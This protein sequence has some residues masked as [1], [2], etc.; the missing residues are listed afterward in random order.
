MSYEIDQIDKAVLELIA[1]H[2][3]GSLG[4]YAVYPGLRNEEITQMTCA[5]ILRYMKNRTDSGV[6]SS[7]CGKYQ[8]IRVS[9]SDTINTAGIDPRTTLYSEEVQD[10]LILTRLKRYRKHNDW[11]S[12]E[13]PTDKYM[14]KLAQEFASMPVPYAMKGASRQL[15]K[16]QSYYAGDGLNSAHHDPDTLYTQLE[17]IKAGGTGEITSVDVTPAGPNQG[18]SVIGTSPRTQ[19]ERAVSGT[20]ST[21]SPDRG[22]PG[23]QPLPNSAL[24]SAG[25]VY[26]Y[27]PIDP[28]DDRYDFRTGTHVRD[29][30]VYGTD[31]VA[32]N[33]VVATN[34]GESNSVI[35]SGV[36][37]PDVDGEDPRGKDQIPQDPT[38]AETNDTAAATS[39]ADDL[40]A[41]LDAFGGLGEPVSDQTPCP[42]PVTQN[43]PQAEP[44]V[45]ITQT[46]TGTNDETVETSKSVE[47]VTPRDTKQFG[48][49][50]ETPA[51][52]REQKVQNILNKT[53]NRRG[54]ARKASRKAEIY[55]PGVKYKHIAAGNGK[56]IV[57]EEG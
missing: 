6:R 33:P 50:N 1:K 43:L 4:Y 14:I 45:V 54:D 25:D 28:L 36:I 55:N 46:N 2:E 20:G 47:E 19:T 15:N 29:I 26:V 17:D 13:L 51:Q 9:L 7:A 32:S 35:D 49:D 10:F 53:Y 16:G 23:A 24:P 44:T 37:H 22:H 41:E 48:G 39:S 34:V 5:Q 11:K 57:V 3:S 56:Y 12:G 31:S 42:E 8:F 18:Q 40:A 30:G 27:R 52:R 38:P 21:A